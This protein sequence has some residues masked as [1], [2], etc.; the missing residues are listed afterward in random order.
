[1]KKLILIVVALVLLSGCSDNPRDPKFAERKQEVLNWLK[2]PGSAKF[3]DTF[4]INPGSWY[5][6]CG[7]VNSKNS[8]GGYAGFQKFLNELGLVHFGKFADHPDPA[9]GNDK[10][11][12][13]CQNGTKFTW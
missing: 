3:R 1:M 2:D 9:L 13:E 11:W 6:L 5:I 4:Y 8:M 12:K 7:Y 10:K